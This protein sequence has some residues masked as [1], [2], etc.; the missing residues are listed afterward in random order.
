LEVEFISK[1][2]SA[3]QVQISSD[4]RTWTN[5]GEPIPGTGDL[6]RKLYSVRGTNARFHRVEIVALP[7]AA[8]YR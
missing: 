8:Q 6:I 2:G 5:L 3:Y 7:V 1:L 4:L